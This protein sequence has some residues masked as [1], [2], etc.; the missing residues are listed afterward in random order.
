MDEQINAAI[1]QANIR[2]SGVAT[3]PRKADQL[4]LNFLQKGS[5]NVFLCSNIY[6]IQ[7]LR[8]HVPIIIK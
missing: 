1:S 4:W 7:R 5:K 3:D 2:S 6:V 8:P